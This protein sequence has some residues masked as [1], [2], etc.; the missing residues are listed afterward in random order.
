[1]KNAAFWDMDIVRT[2]I[3]EERVGSIFWVY[4]FH[5]EYGGD[6]FHRSIGSYKIHTAPNPRTQ[7][8]S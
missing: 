8:S 3:S 6:T 2:D 7:H 1:V 5:P 4:F